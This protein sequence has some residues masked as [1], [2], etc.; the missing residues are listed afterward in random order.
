MLADTADTFVAWLSECLAMVRRHDAC[1][2]LKSPIRH[3][4]AD[5][6]RLTIGRLQIATNKLILPS[7]LSYLFMLRLLPEDSYLLKRLQ[8][9]RKRNVTKRARPLLPETEATLVFVYLWFS[10]I[11]QTKLKHGY[12][13]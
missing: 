2:F 8:S 13:M 1:R 11:H 7:Y 12:T 4:S 6:R 10:N 5:N 3:W 9:A